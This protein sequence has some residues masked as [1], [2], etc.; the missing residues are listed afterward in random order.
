MLYV[1]DAGSVVSG[2]MDLLVE[3]S[4]GYWIID[5]KSDQVDDLHGRFAQ[6]LLQLRCYAEALRKACPQKP[7]LGCGVNW[8]SKG[9]IT[10]IAAD[11][12]LLGRLLDGRFIPPRA[13]S[14]WPLKRDPAVGLSLANAPL[15]ASAPP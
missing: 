7:V 13:G 6:Y 9:V 5:H 1:N 12:L 10:F 4:R 11:A 2:V 3:N 8:I 14:D 15:P